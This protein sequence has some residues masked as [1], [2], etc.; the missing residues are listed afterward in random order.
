MA[1][2][3]PPDDDRGNGVSTE[4]YRPEWAKHVVGRYPLRTVDP[5]TGIPN[6]QVIHME[7]ETCGVTWQTTCDSGAV[8]RHIG[9]FATNHVHTDP[10]E[11]NR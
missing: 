3:Q 7:C 8:R 1:T 6:P 11:S 2:A 5:E 10:M 9:N 4:E